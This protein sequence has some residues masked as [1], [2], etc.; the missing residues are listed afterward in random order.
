MI[1]KDRALAWAETAGHALEGRDCW[2]YA[3]KALTTLGWPGL[4]GPDAVQGTLSFLLRHGVIQLSTPLKDQRD[5]DRLYA[6]VSDQNP[7]LCR[8]TSRPTSRSPTEC[9]ILA[10]AADPRVLK[11]R[12]AAAYLSISVAELKRFNVGRIH[13]GSS[14][15]YDKNALDAYLDEQSGLTSRHATHIPSDDAEDA[16]DRSV[17]ALPNAPRPS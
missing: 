13:F 15:R 14:V 6:Q 16:F 5:Q 9:R 3:A 2:P 11:V 8:P 12:E 10:M 17:P 7:P 4:E 1:R